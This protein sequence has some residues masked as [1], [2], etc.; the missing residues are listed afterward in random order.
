MVIVHLE[1]QLGNWTHDPCHDWRR[2]KSNQGAPGWV[3]DMCDMMIHPD[4]RGWRRS[5]G[6]RLERWWQ[7]RQ[8]LLSMQVPRVE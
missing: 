3:F 5:G 8:T 2:G 6:A 1:R 4:A 7:R